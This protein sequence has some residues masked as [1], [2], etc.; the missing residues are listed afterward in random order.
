[1]RH[2]VEGSLRRIRAGVVKEDGK[3]KGCIFLICIPYEQAAWRE[4]RGKERGQ[5][6]GGRRGGGRKMGW[7]EREREKARSKSDIKI[8][9]IREKEEGRREEEKMSRSSLALSQKVICLLIHPC[10]SSAW[11]AHTHTHIDTREKDTTTNERKCTS[12]CMSLLDVDKTERKR[13]WWRWGRGRGENQKEPTQPTG[14]QSQ[15]CWGLKQH[16]SRQQGR[17]ISPSKKKKKIW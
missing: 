7:G 10:S 2:Q 17:D 8:C 12:I 5:E 3:S 4:V 14:R 6:G 13:W 9:G 16:E 11:H 1:M 15:R